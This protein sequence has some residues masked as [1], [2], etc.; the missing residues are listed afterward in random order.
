AN[1]HTPTPR[2]FSRASRVC[3]SVSILHHQSLRARETWCLSRVVST[4]EHF[5][6]P[7]QHVAPRLEIITLPDAA[8][9]NRFADLHAVL[10]L[11]EC[12]VVHDENAGL[13]YLRQL[14][15]GA[16]RCFYTIVAAVERPRAAKHAVPRATSAEFNGS[17]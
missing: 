16:F 11:D 17:C 9:R 12:N 6:V 3:D 5:L 10:A 15:D 13:A 14:F 7:Q 4:A 1:E 2:N 8:A